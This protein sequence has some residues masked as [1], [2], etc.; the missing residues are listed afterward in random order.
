MT[1]PA[2]HQ[3]DLYQQ[4]LAELTE[5]EGGSLAHPPEAANDARLDSSEQASHGFGLL[6][7]LLGLATAVVAGGSLLAAGGALGLLA[8][9]AT[10]LLAL[11]RGSPRLLGAAVAGATLATA[12]AYGLSPLGAA[13]AVVAI[14]VALG[15]LFRGVS[16]ER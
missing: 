10:P 5:R 15:L 14:A 6:A 3:E 4:L 12:A 7:L 11:E 9:L 8:V 16:A 13:L 2:Q 1:H